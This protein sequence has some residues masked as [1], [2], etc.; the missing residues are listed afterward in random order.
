M[1]VS[2]REIVRV[3]IVKIDNF[4]SFGVFLDLYY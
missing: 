2:D 3:I 1:T 4:Y